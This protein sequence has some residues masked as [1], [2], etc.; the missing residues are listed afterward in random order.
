MAGNKGGVALSFNY[1]DTTIA[2]CTSHLAAGKV[3][4]IDFM[5]FRSILIFFHVF[6]RSPF[7]FLK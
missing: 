6:F 4:F 3:S 5:I 7:R 1:Y 2:L